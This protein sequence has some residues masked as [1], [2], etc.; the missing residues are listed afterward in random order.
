M[1]EPGIHVESSIDTF[2]QKNLNW[3]EREEAKNN[4]LLGLCLSIKNK[5]FPCERPLLLTIQ[6]DKGEI[7]AAIQTHPQSLILSQ[8]EEDS[9]RP[10]VSFLTQNGFHLPGVNGPHKICEHFA[11]DWAK[12][13]GVK[14]K[15]NYQYLI[16]ELVKLIENSHGDKSNGS[17]ELA[18]HADFPTIKKWAEAFVLEAQQ[19]LKQT[20]ESYDE[21]AHRRIKNKEMYLWKVN[22][23]AV[24]MAG[25]SGPTPHGI[26]INSVY[27]PLQH[28]KKGYS[29]H[30]VA[31]IA[32]EMLNLGKTSCYIYADRNNPTSNGIYQK[33]GFRHV[34]ESSAIVFYR[35]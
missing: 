32:K 21:L 3:L 35:E 33:I 27:T 31:A 28:R 7:G 13:N 29:G 34:A 11:N 14:Y 4:L 22:N 25:V 1:K 26:R 30:C 18:D 24:S 12:F 19:G 5:T 15:T 6:N 9:I 10:L 8:I 16:Y 20:K 17:L 23:I 2:L